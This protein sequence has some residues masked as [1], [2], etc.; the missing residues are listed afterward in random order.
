VSKK[1]FHFSVF[2][3]L[4]VNAEYEGELRG[5]WSGTIR[6]IVAETGIKKSTVWDILNWLSDNDMIVINNKNGKQQKNTV[7]TK[8]GQESGQKT[9]QKRTVIML[10]NYDHFQKSGQT[11]GQS[12]DKLSGVLSLM[13]LKHEEERNIIHTAHAH[14]H[15][16]NFKNSQESLQKFPALKVIDTK[17]VQNQIQ[18]LAKIFDAVVLW[19]DGK[20]SIRA[21]QA[22]TQLTELFLQAPDKDQFLKY[23]EQALYALHENDDI[24]RDKG[25]F[26]KN[27]EVWHTDQHID[28]Y[29][30][31]YHQQGYS[32]SPGDFFAQLLE[33]GHA[34]K[35]L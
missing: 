29:I 10:K 5:H 18:A 34:A 28:A 1:P 9:P 33:V 32:L 2:I 15:E 6:Q 30:R 8:S 35:I 11:P 23:Y 24:Y 3:Y 25:R 31:E 22:F 12:P 7:R 13:Y 21:D 14:A 19:W 20:R 17:Q 4:I 27:I 16:G 26:L